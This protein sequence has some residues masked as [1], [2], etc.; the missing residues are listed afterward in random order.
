[1]SWIT[2]ILKRVL[3]ED[4]EPGCGYWIFKLPANHPFTRA[5]NLHDDAFDEAHKGTHDLTLAEEDWR[6]FF[7][8]AMIARAAQTP[9]ERCALVS[10]ICKYWPKARWAGKYLWEGKE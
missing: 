3:P 1:M 4:P 5:C 10:E 2:R 8:W 9:E 7:R 6:L